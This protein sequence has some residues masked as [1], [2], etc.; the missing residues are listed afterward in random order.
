MA[1]DNYR[2]FEFG[3]NCNDKFLVELSL[4]VSAVFTIFQKSLIDAW[5]ILLDLALV[6]GLDVFDT[7][8]VSGPWIETL[9]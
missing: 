9:K 4:K 8:A 5:Q 6:H 2:L 7:G 1:F 3:F